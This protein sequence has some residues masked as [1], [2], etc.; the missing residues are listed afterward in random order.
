[1]VVTTDNLLVSSPETL[2]PKNSLVGFVFD[3][4]SFAIIFKLL[5]GVYL[6][7]VDKDPPPAF[8]LEFVTCYM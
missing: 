6:A 7:S 5:D 3:T 2:T 1:M 8:S 4:W